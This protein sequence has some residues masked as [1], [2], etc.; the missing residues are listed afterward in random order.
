M[1]FEFKERLVVRIENCFMSLPL[2]PPCA[3][4]HNDSAPLLLGEV[5]TL[6]LR[7]QSSDNHWA[8]AWSGATSTSP[9][10]ENLFLF[11]N[12]NYLFFVILIVIVLIVEN[13]YCS[14]CGSLDYRLLSNLRSV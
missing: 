13:C 5:L 4:P 7:S 6:E 14:D 1:E 11:F 8:V 2:V 12:L 9:A 10:I 3:N